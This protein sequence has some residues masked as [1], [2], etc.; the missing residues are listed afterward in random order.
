LYTNGIGP[1]KQ[2][3]VKPFLFKLN[4]FVINTKLEK[5]VIATKSEAG[6]KP[7]KLQSS[8]TLQDDVKT[9]EKENNLLNLCITAAFRAI[10][11]LKSSHTHAIADAN[12]QANTAVQ[13]AKELSRDRLNW[14]R[15]NSAAIES[16][17]D[18]ALRSAQFCLIFL[19]HVRRSYESDDRI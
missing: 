10:E 17:L 5:E 13:E 7:S 2:E 8:S 15:N 11:E 6:T 4:N 16:K 1:L 14:N 12:R 9:L 19:C 3:D 18:A